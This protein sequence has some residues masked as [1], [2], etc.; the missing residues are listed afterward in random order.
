M[1]RRS[2]T[3][4]VLLSVLSVAFIWVSYAPICELLVLM[5]CMDRLLAALRT[6]LRPSEHRAQPWWLVVPFHRQYLTLQ[7]QSLEQCQRHRLYLSIRPSRIWPPIRH[8]QCISWNNETASEEMG[9]YRPTHGWPLS[10]HEPGPANEESNIQ[11]M[12]IMDLFP[13]LFCGMNLFHTL[14]YQTLKTIM[15]AY[16]SLYWLLMVLLVQSGLLPVLVT[17]SLVPTLDLYTGNITKDNTLYKWKEP[18][19]KDC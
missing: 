8:Q 11:Q 3:A 13:T 14:W 4:D 10:R 16:T 18:W 15:C 9:T 5:V 1:S 12:H 17:L 7:R 6:A 19:P 2:D